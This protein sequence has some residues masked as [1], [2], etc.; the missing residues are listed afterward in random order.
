M[1]ILDSCTYYEV[2]LLK[3]SDSFRHSVDN[4]YSIDA[5]TVKLP[6]SLSDINKLNIP[7]EAINYDSVEFDE[8]ELESLLIDYIGKHPAYL[9]FASGCKWNGV[10]GY[11]ICDDIKN[12][13]IRNY[14]ISLILINQFKNGIECMEYS[15]DVPTGSPTYILG[16]SNEDREKIED[17]EFNDIENYVNT[18]I[19]L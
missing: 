14:D 12:T 4:V 15:H 19:K 17:M 8:Y 1:N 10:S 13:V 6:I 5:D 18:R 7:E 3:L 9:V 2:D 16:I 11:K